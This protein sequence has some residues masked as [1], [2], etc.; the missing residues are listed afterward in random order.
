MIN[1][2]RKTH[3]HLGN[4]PVNYVSEAGNNLKSYIITKESIYKV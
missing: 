4:A 2:V 1:E 3:F